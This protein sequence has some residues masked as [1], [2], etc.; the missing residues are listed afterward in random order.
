MHI[1]TRD[2]IHN[3]EIPPPET[4]LRNNPPNINVNKIY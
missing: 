2:N 3:T 4:I 1:S